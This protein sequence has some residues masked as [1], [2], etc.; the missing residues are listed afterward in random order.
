MHFDNETP[1][2]VVS[3][4]ENWDSYLAAVAAGAFDCIDFPPY[5]EELER[6]LCLALS[7]CRS[8]TDGNCTPSL[9]RINYHF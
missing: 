7:E 2:V 1:L 5:P 6:I 4:T 3:H 9:T 8:R